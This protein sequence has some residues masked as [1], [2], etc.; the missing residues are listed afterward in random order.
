MSWRRTLFEGMFRM[1]GLTRLD[2]AEPAVT[3][4]PSASAQLGMRDL[5]V[6]QSLLSAS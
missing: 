2:F 5:V 6:R 4:F 1:M 3:I